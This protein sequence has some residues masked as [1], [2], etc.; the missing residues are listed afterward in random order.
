L[1]NVSIAC[2]FLAVTIGMFNQLAGINA[3]L[4]YLNPIFADAGFTKSPR[5]F[6]RRHRRHQT[7]LHHDAMTLIDK[8]GRKK[9]L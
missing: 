1:W 3:I 5:S 7:H 6:I 8:V 4:Y 2:V 9:A